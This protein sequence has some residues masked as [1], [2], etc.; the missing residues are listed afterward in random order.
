MGERA[1]RIGEAARRAG[2]STDTLRHYERVG[3]LP[4]ATRTDA[5][6]RQYP[7]ATID[8][9]RFVRNALRFGF[10][11]KQIAKF[12][13]ARDSGGAPCQDVRRAAAQ[14]ASEMDRQID[15]LLAARAEIRALLADWDRRLSLTPAG[16]PARL[17]TTLDAASPSVLRPGQ[18][19]LN[20]RRA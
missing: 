10:S 8:R 7:E 4:K 19:R 14:M 15:E 13:R 9:V 12:L 5:G 16:A 20:R 3:V 11:L 17:L 2:V 18:P 1:F 6:Y